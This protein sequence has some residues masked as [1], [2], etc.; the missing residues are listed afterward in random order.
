M[1]VSLPLLPQIQ[2]RNPMKNHSGT[3]HLLSSPSQTTLHLCTLMHGHLPRSLPPPCPKFH[4]PS[5]EI[6]T[7]PSLNHHLFDVMHSVSPTTM[8]HSLIH[9]HHPNHHVQESPNLCHPT[10]Y[11]CMEYQ[12][13]PQSYPQTPTNLLL[14]AAPVS[15]PYL[16]FLE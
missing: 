16:S 5:Y 15:R 12:T 14:V 1:T 2:A 7:M 6:G 11:G 13:Y 4:Q 10:E 8:T 9:L 3:P